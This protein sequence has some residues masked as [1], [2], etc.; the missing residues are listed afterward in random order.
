MLARSERE[1][2]FEESVLGSL[3]TLDDLTFLVGVQAVE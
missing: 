1:R 2:G 3:V